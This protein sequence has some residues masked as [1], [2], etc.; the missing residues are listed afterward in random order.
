MIRPGTT[1][2]ALMFTLAAWANPGTA[3]DHTS[4]P[5]APSM[6]GKTAG[7]TAARAPVGDTKTCRTAAE[8]TRRGAAFLLAAQDREGAWGTGP[9]RVGITCLALKALIQEPTVGGT[10]PAV[11]RGVAFVRRFQR[12]DG[13][14]YSA[15]GLLKNYESSVALSMFAALRRS[16]DGPAGKDAYAQE[17]AALQAFLK[18]NQWDESEDKS[19]DDPWYGGAGYGRHKRPD[20][21]NTQIM[22][23]A[24]HDSGLPK[25][26]PV[27]RKALVFIRR[28]QMLGESNDQPC[29]QG[30]AQ[31]GFI[32]TCANGG[33]SKAGYV[34]IGGR[35]ELRCY[36]S[37]TYAGLKSMV[38][39]GLTRDDPRVRA[40]LG[41]I[42]RHWTLDQNPNMPAAQAWQGLFYYYH[43]FGRALAA[44]GEPV[45]AD[46]AERSHDWRRE[47]VAKLAELQRPDGRWVNDADRWME[48]EPALTTAYALLALQA[49]CPP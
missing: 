46:A 42:R 4:P 13:G 8:L 12:A 44:W 38:Y 45:I 25:D 41:W 35:R 17:V 37:M 6:D 2:A 40:A 33:E 27:Y 29:A 31:G 3:A 28:C 20:L 47:L 10:H 26:D 30:S 34:E 9:G 21:S 14:I 48:G 22:L 23:E 16:A 43:V 1:L 39:A 7:K 11:Q 32:Y 5:R 19:P 15:E 24:L 18:R 36:G 49:A